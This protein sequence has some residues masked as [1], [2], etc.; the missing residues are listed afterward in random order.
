[1]TDKRV[2][3]LCALVAWSLCTHFTASQAFAIPVTIRGFVANLTG[4]PH[5]RPEITVT[6]RIVD[7][8]NEL[9]PQ[10]RT[11]TTSAN[12]NGEFVFEIPEDR[13]PEGDS[14]VALS[15]SGFA[16][17]NGIRDAVRTDQELFGLAGQ[18][19]PDFGSRMPDAKRV[20]QF[21]V[22]VVPKA[23]QICRSYNCKAWSRCR[24]RKC[25]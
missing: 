23:K 19:G 13:I 22:L 10:E 6:L 7:S 17:I 24:M 1:M 25:R 21:I 14:R 3:I 2:R 18:I 4:V 9:S 16:S 11:L 8:G 15:A 12:E 5:I 20:S